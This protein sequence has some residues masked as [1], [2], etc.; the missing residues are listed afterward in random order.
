MKRTRNVAVV[1]AS[2][3]DP[4]IASLALEVGREIAKQKWILI[5]GGLGGVMEEASRGAFEQGGMTVGILPGYEHSSGNRYLTVT[6]PTG[7]GHARNAVI[8]AAADGMVAVG[9]EY[10]TLSEISLA[11]KMDKPVVALES[12]GTLPAVKGV[13]TVQEAIRILKEHLA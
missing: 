6:I 13:S 3:A 11:L 7:L 9:G 5:C 1:G 10:G 8:A 12:W 2:R 4:K